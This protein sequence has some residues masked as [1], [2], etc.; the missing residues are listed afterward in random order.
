LTFRKDKVAS[1]FDKSDGSRWIALPVGRW[2]CEGCGDAYSFSFHAISI[3]E[4]SRRL[5]PV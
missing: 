5:M 1:L 2:Y 4:R 3:S